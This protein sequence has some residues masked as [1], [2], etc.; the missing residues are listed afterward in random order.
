MMWDEWTLLSCSVPAAGRWCH[1]GPCS[2]QIHLPPVHISSMRNMVCRIREIHVTNSEKYNIYT[3]HTGPSSHHIHLP[4]VHISSRC[5]VLSFSPDPVVFFLLSYHFLATPVVSG[6]L[7][8]NLYHNQ[9][10]FCH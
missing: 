1:T 9:L 6:H 2:H 3:R 7:C 8:R 10:I 5:F 4:P